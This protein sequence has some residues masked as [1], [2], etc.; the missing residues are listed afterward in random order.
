[1]D[2][3][4][5]GSHDLI[6]TAHLSVN[7]ILERGRIQSRVPLLFKHASAGE[8]SFTNAVVSEPMSFIDHLRAGLHINFSVA[9]DF[10][11]SNGD[12]WLPESLHFRGHGDTQY[13]AAIKGV[14]SVLSFYS[15]TQCAPG[16]RE[17]V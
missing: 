5:D 1:M 4:D 17:I 9:V 11:K 12:P 13:E 6:G 3:D 8:L 14:A 15:S 2:W 16:N 7:E 10:T